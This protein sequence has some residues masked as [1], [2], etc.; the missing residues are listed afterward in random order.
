MRIR[1]L[2]IPALGAAIFLPMIVLASGPYLTLSTYSGAPGSSV[3]V[4]GNGF[5]SA[6][7]NVLVSMQGQSQT[8]SATVN[9]GSFSDATLTVPQVPPGTYTIMATSPQ[10][11]QA[12]TNFY[13]S[14]YYPNASPSGWYVVPGQSLSIS[15][16][17]WPPNASIT[18]QGGDGTMTATTNGSGAFT[19]PTITVPYKWQ[20]STQ[21]FVVSGSGAAYSVPMT[22]TIGTFYPNLN[23]SSYYVAQ[24]STM[25][26]S[27]SGFSPNEIVYVMLN[28]ALV[29][30][31]TADGSGKATVSFATPNTTGNVTLMAQGASSGV[32]VSRT[33]TLY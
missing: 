17:G 3:Q 13:V 26:A 27:M 22:I 15:G 2:I 9:N 30:Q 14:G 21:T 23:P 25:S 1:R 29:A 8:A 6:S 19:S 4:S 33:I 28:G 18:I 16:S 32:S 5:G 24:G 20:N 10:R 31:P 11:E 12:S 7:T